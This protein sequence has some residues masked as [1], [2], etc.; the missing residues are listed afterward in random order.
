MGLELYSTHLSRA[1]VGDSQINLKDSMTI[2]KL[3]Q[4]K[5][6]LNWVLKKAHNL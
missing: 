6:D 1:C 5:V 4:L 3:L 2:Y